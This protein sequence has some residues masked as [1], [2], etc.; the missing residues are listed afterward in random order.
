MMESDIRIGTPEEREQLGSREDVG[1][2]VLWHPG[3]P[4]TLHFH[5]NPYSTDIVIPS[6]ANEAIKT[7][8]LSKF[9][10]DQAAGELGN[11]C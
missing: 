11:W 10:Q 9:P 3:V 7:H 8:T 1:G 5:D 2:M 6:F 4:F